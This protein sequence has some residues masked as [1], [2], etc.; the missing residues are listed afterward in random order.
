M[1]TVED[2]EEIRRA[3]FVEGLSIRA[4][5]R[6]LKVDR[7]TIRKAIVEPT[8]KPYQLNQPRPAPVLG[9]YQERIK[10]LLDESERLPRKQRYTAQKIFQLIRAEGYRG[11]AGSVHN[12]VCGERKQRKRKEAFLPLEFD[13]GQDAQVDW[14]EVTVRM[15][16]QEIKVQF[17]SMRLNYSKARFVMAFPFQKQEAFF[18]GHIQAFHFFG[19]VP[20]RITYDNLKTAVYRILKGKNRQEQQAYK[21]FRSYYLCESHYCT[22]G[23][24]H[25]KGGI[26]NDIGYAQRNFFSPIPEV[27]GFAELNAHL[28]ASCR[29]DAQRRTRGQTE[30][31]AELWQAEKTLLLSLPARDFPACATRVVKPNTYLQVDCDTNRYSVPYDYR[32]RQLVLRAYPFRIELLYLDNVIADHP[33][34][35]QKEQDI[36]D[37]LHYLPLLVQRPGA[38]EHAKPLRRWRKQWPKSYERLLEQLRASQPDGRGVRE[39]LEILR[40]HLEHP[41]T[42]VERAVEL[43]L[44]LGAAHLDGVRLCLRQLLAPEPAPRSLDLSSHP[45]LSQV[46]NQPVDLGQYDQLL[47]A[48]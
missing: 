17:F 25:E 36:L 2:F 26:E 42:L 43:A 15:A 32:D 13:A 5:H 39:F 46:G 29:E 35:F 14:G 1:K 48:R 10:E 45:A 6:R 8:P 44:E 21:E 28:G 19:G 33:R 40:L 7:R 41:Q 23:Q 3:Y 24:A 4:I 11:C 9:P 18:E 37:P 47:G 30:L 20:R 34:C 22:P 38:F 16:G 27:A 31:V 12:Y